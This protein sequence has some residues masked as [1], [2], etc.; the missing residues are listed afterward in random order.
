MKY[1]VASWMFRETQSS[2]HEL[3]DVLASYGCDAVS[4]SLEQITRIPLDERGAF[5][6]QLRDLDL[7]VTIHTGCHLQRDGID[8]VVEVLGDRLLAITLDRVKREQS[9]GILYDMPRM[10]A[11]LSEIRDATKGTEIRFGFEDLPLDDQAI[12]FYRDDIAG[13]L[14]DP[15]YGML[16]DIGHL[17]IRMTQSDYFAGTCTDYVS[18]IPVPV[19]EVHIHDND[20]KRDLHAPMGTGTV[21]FAEVAAGLETIGFSG[22]ATIE[23]APDL[24]GASPEEGLPHV[25]A[26]LE[27][28]RALTDRTR[29][30]RR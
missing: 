10:A 18:R 5:A 30:Q 4:F 8:T 29:P 15:R 20:G 28:W 24:H 27:T 12:N 25:K 7:S 23:I 17:H 3:V 19:I 11:T 14:D 1:A 6:Q 2:V 26:D 9:H 16:M 13:F 22:V 21:P